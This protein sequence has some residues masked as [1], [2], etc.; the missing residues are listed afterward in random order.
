M[1]RSSSDPCSRPSFDPL[2]LVL[3]LSEK[4]KVVDLN[5]YESD[6]RVIL[7]A[8]HREGYWGPRYLYLEALVHT[9]AALDLLA[10]LPHPV[11]PRM[12]RYAYRHG[13]PRLTSAGLP[14]D[15]HQIPE[16]IDAEDGEAGRILSDFLVRRKAPRY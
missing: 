12:P 16:G 4:V 7:E 2:S 13:A 9:L 8:A 11:H 10:E 1:S 6:E 5:I 14:E 15:W 3:P